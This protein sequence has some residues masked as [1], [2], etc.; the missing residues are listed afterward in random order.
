MILKAFRVSCLACLFSVTV[1]AVG[2]LFPAA[3]RAQFGSPNED[4]KIIIHV[5]TTASGRPCSSSKARARCDEMKVNASLAQNYYAFVCVVDGKADAGI[6]GLQFGLNFNRSRRV[7]VDISDWKSCGN[8]EFPSPQNKVD[9]YNAGNGGNLITWSPTDNCQRSE[10]S[11][12]GTGVTAV[13]GYFYL[14]S[15]TADKLEVA[16]RPNDGV[17]K[18]ADCN[19]IE[20][21]VAGPDAPFRNTS[22]LGFVAFSDGGTVPG[23]NPCGLSRPV[24][25][26][27]WTGVKSSGR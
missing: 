5:A 24:V 6:A 1:T 17:A 4:A 23:S 10:P 3:A 13:A 19:S 15:Y 9:W 11:G 12:A 20:S 21:I 26:T 14:T 2:A 22:Y 25:E 16:V 18:V 8:L 27:T 7:G